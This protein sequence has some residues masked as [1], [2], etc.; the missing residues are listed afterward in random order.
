MTNKSYLFS[1]YYKTSNGG[2]KLGLMEKNE[3]IVGYIPTLIEGKFGK[4][5]PYISSRVFAKSFANIPVGSTIELEINLKGWI[6][7][8]SVLGTN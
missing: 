2:Y 8:A 6:V 4:D 5:M 7:G 3:H 1:G